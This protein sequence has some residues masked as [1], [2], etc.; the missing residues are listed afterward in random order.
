VRNGYSGVEALQYIRRL[1]KRLVRRHSLSVVAIEGYSFGER[2]Y[3]HQMGE[4]GGTVRI[5]SADLGVKLVVIPPTVAKKVATGKGN[6][7]KSDVRAAV[8]AMYSLKRN[9]NM[10]ISDAVAVYWAAEKE[11]GEDRNNSL[12]KE[13]DVQS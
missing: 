12:A 3:T 8:R 5:T 10:N 4:V 2:F 6:A 13:K 9:P 1:V 11:L 7:S